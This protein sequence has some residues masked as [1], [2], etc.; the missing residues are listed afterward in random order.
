MVVSGHPLLFPPLVPSPTRAVLSQVGVDTQCR[1]PTLPTPLKT[2][3]LLSPL[4][5]G[6]CT[7]QVPG[8]VVHEDQAAGS[9]LF[10]QEIPWPVGSS[11]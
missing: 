1:A 10:G 8:K 9:G 2:A 3:P 4:N 11:P 5:L 7:L 6:V